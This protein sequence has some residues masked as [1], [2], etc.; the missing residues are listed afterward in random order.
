MTVTTN[1]YVC[2]RTILVPVVLFNGRTFAVCRDA[3]LR[4]REAGDLR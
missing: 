1:C 3:H 4:C 2:L